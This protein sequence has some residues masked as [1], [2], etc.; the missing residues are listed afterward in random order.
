MVDFTSDTHDL[1]VDTKETQDIDDSLTSHDMESYNEHMKESLDEYD[2]QKFAHNEKNRNNKCEEGK[3]QS[4]NDISNMFVRH[5]EEL[6][7][8]KD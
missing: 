3:E 5:W 8:N 4:Q 2:S 6:S 7:F 1:M